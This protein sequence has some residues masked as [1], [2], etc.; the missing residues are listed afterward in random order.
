M[1]PIPGPRRPRTPP[2]RP[3]TRKAE[4]DSQPLLVIASGSAA[5]TGLTNYIKELR[6]EVDRE[7]TVLMTASAERFVRPE[8]VGW[9]A[10]QVLTSDTPG[11]QPVQ[12]A[13]T[14]RA[15]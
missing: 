8:V 3:R 5:L 6:I 12:L 7:L 2:R 13:K 15:I 11:L 1:K 14:A 10:D 9:F 4:M